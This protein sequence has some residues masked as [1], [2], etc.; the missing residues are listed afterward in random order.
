MVVSFPRAW[1]ATQPLASRR[2]V[3]VVGVPTGAV[4][5]TETVALR[6][7]RPL[8]ALRSAAAAVFVRVGRTSSDWPPGTVTFSGAMTAVAGFLPFAG[9]PRCTI[10]TVTVAW[11]VVSQPTRTG[12]LR[13]V[14]SFVARSTRTVSC[15]P[16]GAGSVGSLGAGGV[17]SAASV[18]QLVDAGLMSANCDTRL[19]SV[20]VTL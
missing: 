15:G 13:D 8:S 18:P 4:A 19:L 11:Q 5:V 9:L 17:P 2:L 1:P 16:S 3:T 14:N 12:R 6:P 20:S 10:V 7:L